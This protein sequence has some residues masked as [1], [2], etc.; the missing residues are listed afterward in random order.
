MNILKPTTNGSFNALDEECILWQ[1]LKDNPPQWWMNIL[2]DKELYVEIRKDNYANVYYYGGN[3]AK[4]QWRNGK[5]TAETHQKYLGGHHGRELYKD[6]ITM[7]QNK[8]NL[9]FIKK[10]IRQEYH[11]L[12]QRKET[13]EQ[14][15]VHISSEK[16]IQGK[17]KLYFPK[18][19]I[20]SE[21]AYRIGK[22][23]LVRFDLA[24]LKESILTFI[25]LKL[26]TD[27]RLRSKG[28]APEIIGQMTRYGDFIR[29]HAKTLKDYYAK[30]LRIKKRIG[31]W[32]GETEI[33]RVTLKPELLIINT[34]KDKLSRQREERIK[35][36]E[37]L[38]EKTIFAT[39][40]INYQDL[41]R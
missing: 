13:D 9:E 22:D 35:A 41:C 10:K 7:L 11:K 23:N 20:D 30:L 15:G 12:P 6:C 27:S 39:S 3:V 14:D 18:R 32:D 36:I 37:K 29:E 40:I 26:I 21:F 28:K 25:E 8:E 16:W 34:Y 1:E 17:L 19:Y 33:E 31:I 38:K 5:I 2:A 4:V 24:E